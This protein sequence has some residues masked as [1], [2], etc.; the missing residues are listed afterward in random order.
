[1]NG[2]AGLCVRISTGACR[3]CEG[4]FDLEVLW[5]SGNALSTT[6]SKSPALG[7]EAAPAWLSETWI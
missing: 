3:R 7:Y 5:V 6:Q 1:M 2:S 4:S